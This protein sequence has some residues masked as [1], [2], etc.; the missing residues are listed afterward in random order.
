M[1]IQP[2]ARGSDP[3]IVE[4]GFTVKPPE[5]DSVEPTQGIVNDE[6]TLK[7]LF[8]GTK[9]GKITLGGKNC[10]VKTWTMDPTS[11]G[12]EVVFVV[13][14]GLSAGTHDLKIINGVGSE[15]TAFAVE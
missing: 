9:K 1:T 5:I 13:P 14:K 8:F 10:R 4:N 7:G 11:G 15:T 2:Q 6:I 12:S 3:I